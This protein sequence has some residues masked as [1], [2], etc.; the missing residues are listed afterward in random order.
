MFSEPV[1][2]ERFFG[3][4]E[5]LDLLNKRA[6]ALKDGYRQNVALTGQS[7]AGK[8]SIIL[9]FLHDIREEG[10][11]PVYVEVIKEP[12]RSF[13]NKFIATMLYNALI[14]KGEHVDIALDSLLATAQDVLPKTSHAVKQVNI[15]IDLGDFDEA[16]L[17][18]LGLTSILK[19]E[20]G[21]PCIVILDEFDNLERLG[22]K[23]PYLSFG[24]VIMVQ[25]DTMYIVS[26]SRNM[27][28]R[29]IISEKLSLLFGNFE[30]IKVANFGAKATCRFMDTK[31]VGFDSGDFIRKFLFAFTDGNP[32]YLDK[33]VS[34]IRELAL[35]R[36]TSHIDNEIVSDAILDTVYNSGG[37][38]H[39]YL[40]NYILD[41]LDTKHKDLHIG[42]LVSI[43]FGSNRQPDIAKALRTKSGEVSKALAY[44]MEKALISKNGTFYRIDDAML[45][46][47]LKN[48][49]QRRKDI[50]VDGAFNR[51]GL[52]R[53]DL[54][55]YIV[56]FEKDFAPSIPSRL[57]ELFGIFSNELVALESKQ[58]RMPRF[59][60]VELRQFSPSLPYIAA[61]FRSNFWIVQAYEKTANEGDIIAFIRNVKALDCKISNK[62]IIP[63]KGIDENARLLAKELRI[64]IWDGPTVNALLTLYRKKRIIIL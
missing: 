33:I 29:K 45:E 51:L 58:M 42:I 61:S 40:M 48:V 28:I 36:M 23:N 8:S 10:F 63:L 9:H 39:Q 21:I 27:A 32:F 35:E 13:A 37:S 49:Y 7:L 60:K 50:L 12:F 52:F 3:R 20:T 26:S 30:V 57:A 62:V 56:S 25:K 47:W 46:F 64:S 17:G 24:K 5:V 55:S 19:E 4:E 16:Y 34:R 53:D 38:I 15:S 31:L 18:L 54:R 1:V 44:L 14:K 41:L 6:S 2:G 43:A 59:T 11:V 22:V